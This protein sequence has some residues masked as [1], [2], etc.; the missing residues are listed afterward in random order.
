[1]PPHPVQKWAPGPLP[2]WV[3]TQH[4]PQILLFCTEIWVSLSFPGWFE[5]QI[6]L[7][8]PLTWLNYIQAMAPGLADRDQQVS[9][10]PLESMFCESEGSQYCPPLTL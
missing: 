9:F 5:C 8:R 3:D 2:C 7:L 4:H 1:M 6:L 10:P